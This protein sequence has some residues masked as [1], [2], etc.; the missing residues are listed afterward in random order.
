MGVVEDGQVGHQ[1]GPRFGF[2]RSFVCRSVDVFDVGLEVGA[3][4][5][6]PSLGSGVGHHPGEALVPQIVG[7]PDKPVSNGRLGDPKVSVI[8]AG[9]LTHGGRQI[10][11]GETGR[12]L[13]VEVGEDEMLVD[14][15][16]ARRVNPDDHRPTTTAANLEAA[17][18]RITSLAEA[19][20]ALLGVLRSAVEFDSPGFVVFQCPPVHVQ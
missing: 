14:P 9:P 8:G 7:L 1:V 20:Y 5:V 6:G 10:V 11:C 3:C 2:G 4:F 13:H 19:G 16:L 15:D 17:P 18:D 12:N